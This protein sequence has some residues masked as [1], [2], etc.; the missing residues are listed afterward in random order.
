MLANITPNLPPTYVVGD[1]NKSLVSDQFDCINPFDLLFF[2]ADGI[3]LNTSGY[4]V[5]ARLFSIAAVANAKLRH[6]DKIA[7]PNDGGFSTC[8]LLFQNGKNGSCLFKGNIRKSTW[9]MIIGRHESYCTPFQMASD[10]GGIWN[11]YP[12][13]VEKEGPQDHW[14]VYFME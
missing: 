9:V 1:E 3:G 11:P 14:V 7:F 10:K 2:D 13:W 8:D 4:Y 12:D 5:C 6:G